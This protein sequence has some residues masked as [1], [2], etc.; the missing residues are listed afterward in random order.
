MGCCYLTFRHLLNSTAAIAEWNLFEW[1]L[2]TVVV[3]GFAIAVVVVA[4]K[5]VVGE[6]ALLAG[7]VEEEPF[8]EV[9]GRTWGT[10][11]AFEALLGPSSFGIT[12]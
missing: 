12:S 7:V 6:G 1:D 3:V 2:L 10:G 4:G 5:D 9:I 8:E 11:L